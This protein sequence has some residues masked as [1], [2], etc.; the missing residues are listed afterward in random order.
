MASIATQL[1]ISTNATHT[2]SSGTEMENR[3][4]NQDSTS[5]DWQIQLAEA[6]TEIEK[7]QGDTGVQ[8]EERSLVLAAF[9]EKAETALTAF[10]AH[11][12]P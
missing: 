7:I 5:T 9:I 3:G 6:K 11:M 10:S 4:L 12:R 1:P 2:I 8:T